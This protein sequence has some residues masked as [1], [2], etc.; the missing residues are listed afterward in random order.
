MTQRIKTLALILCIFFISSAFLACAK[1]PG[2]QEPESETT[3]QTQEVEAKALT[4][5]LLLAWSPANMSDEFYIEAT[6]GFEEYCQDME[7]QA[8]VANADLDEHEQYSQLENWIAMEVDSIAISP[9]DAEYLQPLISE[10]MQKNIVV[11]GIKSEVEGADINYLLDEYA[12]GT[13]IAQNAVRWIEEKLG[14]DAK[15]VLIGSDEIGLAFRAKGIKDTIG[16]ISGISIVD[17]S[18]VSSRSDAVK[19]VEQALQDYSNIDVI[20]CVND[21]FAIGALDALDDSE[22]INKDFYIGG[23]GYTQEAIEVMNEGGS[24][25]RS[26]VD[27]RPFYIGREMAKIMA[28]SVV[29]GTGRET[30][31]FGMYSYWQNVLVW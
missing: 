20:V 2:V 12:Y 22:I 30:E 4:D 6:R 11:A 16:G 28:A 18:K 29:S 25:F 19:A 10:A 14:G 9:V 23:A 17:S 15:V 7:Y 3:M 27:L 1:E 8:L 26:S 31:Y 13:L 5:S 21:D 24:A